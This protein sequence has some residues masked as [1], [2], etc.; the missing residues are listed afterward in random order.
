MAVLYQ[1]FGQM[2]ARDHFGI[3]RQR[4]RA[5]VSAAYAFFLQ[6]GRNRRQPL[7]PS[8]THLCQ[9]RLQRRI[10]FIEIQPDDVHAAAAP[11]NGNLHTVNQADAALRRFGACFGQAAGVVVVGQRQHGTAVG[12]RQPHHF[13][14]A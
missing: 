8:F 2:G 7:Q 14:G 6:F 5:F 4:Q 12:M 13:G 9:Q 1:K 3:G 11:G 10:V